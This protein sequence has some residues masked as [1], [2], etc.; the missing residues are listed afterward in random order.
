MKTLIALFMLALL[1][2]SPAQA[3]D[4]AVSEPA[5]LSAN[6]EFANR[7]I[8][9]YLRGPVPDSL[10][11]HFEQTAKHLVAIGN[12]QAA[13]PL[14]EFLAAS[15]PDSRSHW[16]QLLDLYQR[17]GSSLG[18]DAAG[19][20][21][22]MARNEQERFEGYLR[23]YR[24]HAERKSW[25]KAREALEKAA[26][27]D[28]GA[29][30]DAR[31]AEIDRILSTASV[32]RLRE[33]YEL[34]AAVCIDFS[35]GFA[36]QPAVDYRRFIRLE[37]AHDYQLMEEYGNL[38]I[39]QLHYGQEYQVEI[40]PGLPV[41]KEVTLGRGYRE[42][43]R[44][45][46]REPELSFNSR[47]YILPFH[48]E[49]S[50]PLTTVNIE[51]ADIT[52]Q[53]VNDRNLVEMINSYGLHETLSIRQRDAITGESG[54]L[55]WEADLR[56]SRKPDEKVV[57]AVPLK[58]HWPDPEPGIYV[59]T[60][61]E[62]QEEDEWVYGGSEL[63][64]QWL[65]VSDLGL[66]TLEGKD[67]LHLFVRSL[68]DGTPRADVQLRLLS[69]NNKV[70]GE[71][72]TDAEGYARFAPGLLNGKQA[73]Q[74]RAV[75]A[76]DGGQDFNLL[77]LDVS[78]HDFSDRG[79]A[80]RLAPGPIDAFLYTERGIYR[81]GEP[82][83]FSALLRNDQ[84]EILAG[85]PVMLK[86]LRPNQSVAEE[87][88]LQSDT[89]GYLQTEIELAPNAPGGSWLFEAWSGDRIVG[90]KKIQ[91]EDFVPPRI[92][93]DAE[94]SR[95]VMEVEQP[96]AI[97][98]SARFLYGGK[99][100]GARVEGEV[101]I[102]PV[103][104]P[105][106]EYPGFDFSNPLL[107][108]E[109][110]QFPIEAAETDA[111][112]R[113]SLSFTLPAV[114]TPLPL[115]ASV[116]LSV[117]EPGGR[118]VHR[119]LTLPVRLHEYAVGIR[120]RFE[121]G[122]VGTGDAAG[123]DVVLLR[124]EER[125]VEQ[126]SLA[127]K[128]VHEN[129]LGDWRYIDGKWEYDEKITDAGTVGEGK[130][131]I[132][133]GELGALQLEALPW[134]HYRLELV[135]PSGVVTTAY[136]FESGWYDGGLAGAAPDKLRIALDKAHY[137]VGE[138]A[139]L[140]IHPRFSG[141]ALVTVSDSRLLYRQ[142]LV[143]NRDGDNT[144]ALPTSASWG[145]GVYVMVTAFRT[146]ME[147]K[148][149]MPDRA[150]GVTY[151]PLDVERHRLDVAIEAPERVNSREELIVPVTISGSSGAPAWITLAAVDEGV[152]RMTGFETPDALDH[153]YG[154][155]RMGVEVRDIY[156]RLIRPEGIPG[157]FNVGGGAE[158]EQAA[159]LNIVRTR[160]VVS[161]FSGKLET[162]SEGRALVHL[163]IPDYQGELR[164]MAVAWDGQGRFGTAEQP[165]RIA[166]SLRAELYLPRFLATG[167]MAKARLR[168]VRN[169][170]LPAGD[171]RLSIESDDNILFEESAFGVSVGPDA[172]PD[173]LFD[174]QLVMR[175]GSRVTP[176]SITVSYDLPDGSRRTQEWRIM[177]RASGPA[178]FENRTE[179]LAQNASTHFDDGGREWL[180][181][182]VVVHS[183]ALIDR[184]SLERQLQDYAYRCGEQTTSRGYLG[185]FAAD[186]SD[187]GRRDVTR[188]AIARVL[189]LQHYT[190]AFSL[191]PESLEEDV[192]LTAY[193]L[194]FL[195][196][197]RKA[198][199]QLPDT[200]LREAVGW[201]R[202]Q[203]SRS[204]IEPEAI[205]VDSYVLYVLD[206]AGE[207]VLD[208][209][210]YYLDSKSKYFDSAMGAALLGNAIAGH[211]DSERAD[212]AFR[213]ASE[214]IASGE[215]K[216]RHYGSLLRETAAAIA[217]AAEAGRTPTELG[218]DYARLVRFVGERTYLST[219]EL[220][221]LLRAAHAMEV[222]PKQFDLLV[223]GKRLRD[224]DSWRDSAERPSGLPEL[225]N[226]Q[227]DPLWL[228]FSGRSIRS[229]ATA[230]GG[231]SIRKR[232]H[233]LD[234]TPLQASALGQ[235]ERV[236]VVL[237]G[238]IGKTPG[239]TPLVVDLIPAG[240]ELENPRLQGVDRL[241]TL[242][243]VGE[244]TPAE[245]S[246]Y[247]DDRFV[248]ALE[249]PDGERAFR[250]AYVAQ[251]VTGGEFVVP[252]ALIENMYAPEE[253]AT[254]D[255][256]RLAV[257]PQ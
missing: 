6:S 232:L 255:A 77:S 64:T 156:G 245:Y 100:E 145:A 257:L 65:V 214:R 144:I 141:P 253:R 121:G 160:K 117:Y 247:R 61:M 162:D 184:G 45:A 249:V 113:A 25:K 242:E 172:Q 94:T 54:S 78:A 106:A 19:H 12:L 186:S 21:L 30:I 198:G 168:L 239:Q 211:G 189:T 109:P 176:A 240:L 101:T 256:S 157:E 69:I 86:L 20:L 243:W 248:T 8:R 53:H 178:S 80:G 177:V 237:E 107:S 155:R 2:A 15:R 14:A 199:Y 60:A 171:Y 95:R 1:L 28:S 81:P 138:T 22:L 227:A 174:R 140:H 98:V 33:G 24:L 187:A 126:Q 103:G 241:E 97:D 72:V 29:L 110:Q 165:L 112:G 40:L 99:V 5:G 68:K 180:S 84:G 209:L 197:A 173:V 229:D 91:V 63:A 96:L 182:G 203:L 233:R 205:F 4:P 44:I 230:S 164:L 183:R 123:F 208:D 36:M 151:L 133:P 48:G 67:G 51:R 147:R 246:E 175:A 224:L 70:L 92:A 251:A 74:A 212:R 129:H 223:D 219:Q 41:T 217:L 234:G 9:Q 39:A 195:L 161:L 114:E 206:K 57:T 216:Y 204:S 120:P 88:A 153:F 143:L 10:V 131:L 128:L 76:Y 50:V 93:V 194:D 250:I 115:M 252:P 226:P 83:H 42:P 192:W 244:L 146:G 73:N 11:D 200:Q 137:N 35:V 59:L 124:H 134:G 132:M 185:L 18:I 150:I 135:D 47:Y 163:E 154:K 87:I 16:L 43:F 148:D 46:E 66:F 104:S 55:V 170:T 196:E 102:K 158:E 90:Q 32:S 27:I 213:F 79:V 105:Y 71:T 236:V 89:A 220:A 122:A 139:R 152:L 111:E 193:I 142:R 166:D 118:P 254:S 179:Q 75:L 190:G 225:A 235:N 130:L 218:A 13:L 231:Y 127:W 34:E 210:R 38:C 31:I 201:L 26:A 23:L 228:Q 7:L 238:T 191:W 149:L 52:L 3:A 169:E 85:L 108:H 58:E 207:N 202:R 125:A 222:P 82:V 17:T 49:Q 37:P 188:N 56:I 181:S 119:L 136:R 159:P 116:R 221:W 167:D 215:I 62:H